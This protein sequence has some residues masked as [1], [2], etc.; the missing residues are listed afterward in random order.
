MS[1]FNLLDEPWISVMSRDGRQKDVSLKEVFAHAQDYRRLAGDMETQNFAM[2]RFL[3][4]VI[5]T[6]F[7]RFDS[8]GE[9]YSCIKLDER[10]KQINDIDEDDAEDYADDREACW[11]DLWKKGAFPKIVDQYLEK[12]RD[13]F[14]LYDDKFPFYQVTE[15]EMK[16]L[17]PGKKPTEMKGRNINR[18]IS[19]SNNKTALFSPVTDHEE[20]KASPKDDM[21]SAELARWLIMLQGYVGVADKA[22]LV[23]KDQKPSKGWIYDIGG[24]YAE[25]SNLFETLMLNFIPVHPEFPY[26][27]TA[28]CPCW[29]YSG[30][31]TA[32]KLIRGKTVDNLAS[33]YT[34]W[35]RAISLDP[36][37]EK[38]PEKHVEI[39]KLPGI[40]HQDNFLEPM[41]IWHFNKTGD[42][43]DHYTP[44]KH[45]PEQAVWRNFGLI[46]LQSSNQSHQKKPGI[47]SILDRHGSI[48]GNKFITIHAVSMQDDGGATS[49]VPVDEVTDELSMNDLV[50]SDESS[51][52][53][54]VRIN[55]AVETTRQVVDRYWRFMLNI[56][57][58]RGMDPKKNGKAFADS[59]KEDFY[60]S[61]NN[62]FRNWLA[63]IQP[64][65]SKDH[66]ILT[67]YK[68]LK[69]IAR[70]EAEKILQ[71]ASARDFLG[72][73]DSNGSTTNIVT[74]YQRFIG[75]VTKLLG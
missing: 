44:L 72:I 54:I 35:S 45:K 69:K 7:S 55:E 57:N 5:Q 13:H 3:L 15:K 64:D 20:K 1:S 42:N 66:Q 43:K 2:L 6:V 59:E 60:Q 33:L 24:L 70:D 52:G 67:W 36:E 58:I 63:D 47:I 19:E 28:Q 62:P 56:A 46:T 41:T 31:E 21:T 25:G 32:E 73:K 48:I 74:E 16:E 75:S 26:E 65:D 30:K 50:I 4:A 22:S 49:W 9:P 10:M 27:C 8:N 53:W 39:V 23:Q 11:E 68:E 51:Y 18:L 40:L 38:S 14:Y 29:E 37:Q 34:N 12:W 17:L 61:L 71:N